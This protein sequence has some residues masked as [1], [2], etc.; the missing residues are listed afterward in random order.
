MQGNTETVMDGIDKTKKKL[1]AEPS[2]G[3]DSPLFFPYLRYH[4]TVSLVT[5]HHSFVSIPDHW[6]LLG[7]VEASNELRELY[8]VALNNT[9][10][11]LE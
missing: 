7:S 3:M 9:E 8:K 6:C 1:S 10:Q 4:S 5:I 11:E 2:V